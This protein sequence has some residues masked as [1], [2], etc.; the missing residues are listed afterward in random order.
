MSSF[1]SLIK[2]CVYGW[3]ANLRKMSQSPLTFCPYFSTPNLY[4]LPQTQAVKIDCQEISLPIQ[5]I[6]IRYTTYYGHINLIALFFNIIIIWLKN[7][8]CSPNAFQIKQNSLFSHLRSFKICHQNV[9]F[10]HSSYMSFYLPLTFVLE[11]E[12]YFQTSQTLQFYHP[13]PLEFHSLSLT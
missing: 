6:I 9:S 8:H 10:S 13:L 2:S 1:D 4:L 3:S 11:C 12:L 5:F 7:Q